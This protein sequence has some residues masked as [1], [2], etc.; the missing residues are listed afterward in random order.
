MSIAFPAGSI[1]I[2]GELGRLYGLACLLVGGD[3]G[4]ARSATDAA[5]GHICLPSTGD[6]LLLAVGTAI[7]IAGGRVPVNVPDG[8]ELF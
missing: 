2:A 7:T 4:L 1:M 8:L 5:I 6:T 3:L